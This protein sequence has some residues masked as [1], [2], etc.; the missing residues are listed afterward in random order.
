MKRILLIE[1]NSSDEVLTVRALKKA[2]VANEIIVA[3]DGQEALDYLF[4]ANSHQG[5]D[6]LDLPALALLDLNL[7]KVDGL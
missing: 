3:R 7:P 5:R 1:D 2:N 4:A 6:L